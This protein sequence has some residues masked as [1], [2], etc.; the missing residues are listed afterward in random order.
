MFSYF[1]FYSVKFSFCKDNARPIHLF[2]LFTQNTQKRKGFKQSS[3]H[4]FKP[5]TLI[6]SWFEKSELEEDIYYFLGQIHWI[7]ERFSQDWKKSH[8]SSGDRTG[9]MSTVAGRKAESSF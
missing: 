9:K 5:S 8:Y 6:Q 7:P 4:T 3:K 1:V 2:S